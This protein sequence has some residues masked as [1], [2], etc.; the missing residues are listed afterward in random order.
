MSV[1]SRI[2]QGGTGYIELRRLVDRVTREYVTAATVTA[3]LYDEDGNLVASNISLDHVEKGTY[4]GVL[5][6][7]QT[8]GLRV[9]SIALV[10]VTA[11][12]GTTTMPFED[13]VIV[14]ASGSNAL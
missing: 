13:G 5:T 6:A 7:L 11:T 4:R 1:N 3:S 12:D 8:A 10:R 9:S 14:E 2:V